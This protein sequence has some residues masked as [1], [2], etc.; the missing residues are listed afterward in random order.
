MPNRV[1]VGNSP[2]FFHFKHDMEAA[3][4]C[5]DGD[6]LEVHCLDGFAGRIQREDDRLGAVDVDALN[7]CSGPIRV[8]G[9]EPGDVLAFR[10]DSI[11]VDSDQGCTLVLPDFG[12]QQHLVDT[13]ATRISTIKDGVLRILDRFE[14]PIRPMLGT[15]GVA[16]AEGSW[17]TVFPHDHGGNMDTRDVVAG[18][19]IYFPVF[20]PGALLG[21]GDA[22]ALMGDGELCSTGV[23]VPVTVVGQ[24]RVI[25]GVSINRPIIETPTE[26]MTIGSAVDHLDACRLA[27]GDLIELLQRA[28]DLSWTDAYV[29]TS[30]VSDL[31]ISQVVDPLLTVRAAISKR[32]LPDPF[33]TVAP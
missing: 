29:L 5:E 8:R 26:W 19:T 16:P 9:A 6:I 18:H 15:I 10:I 1:V 2:T 7:D 25:K 3:W 23:E 30:I 17:S 12:L 20:Q 32:F 11:S 21:M 4:E 28:H 33:A 22:K 14:A 27:N 24:V 13:E 31:R